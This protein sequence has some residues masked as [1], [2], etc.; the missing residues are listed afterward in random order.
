MMISFLLVLAIFELRPVLMTN[1][2]TIISNVIYKKALVT[3]DSLNKMTINN[4]IDDG[5]RREVSIYALLIRVSI[6]RLT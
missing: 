1:T 5:K 4:F 3:E 2:A 6:C